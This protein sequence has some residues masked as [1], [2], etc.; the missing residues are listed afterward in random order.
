M[1]R[2]SIF[3]AGRDGLVVMLSLGLTLSMLAPDAAARWAIR[4]TEVPVSRL[5]D[6]T[7]DYIKKNA[8]DPQGYYVLGRL[9]SMAFALGKDQENLQVAQPLGGAPLDEKGLPSFLPWQS[10]RNERRGE[11]PELLTPA[12]LAH[13]EASVRNYRRAVEIGKAA[14]DPKDGAAGENAGQKE[15]RVRQQAKATLGLAWMLEEAANHAAAVTKGIKSP[16][17]AKLPADQQKSL[18]QF[19]AGSGKWR[20]QSLDAYRLVIDQVGEQDR[21]GFGRGPGA[22]SLMS[23]DAAQ[24]IVR[25]LGGK[26]EKTDKDKAEIAK[27]SEL[28]AE[29]RQKPRA[30]TPIIFP[31]ERPQ[32]L[33]ELLAPQTTVTFDLDGDGLASRWPWVRPDTCLLV[34]DPQHNGQVQD[35]RQLF[36]SVTW[37]IF[38]DHGYQPLAS[39]DNDR[40]GW[41]EGKE[42]AGLAAWQDAN[43][44]GVSDPGEVTP[45]SERGIRR[46][47]VRYETSSDGT[48]MNA[49]G[50]ERNDGRMLPTYDWVPRSIAGASRQ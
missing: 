13:L 12:Q 42:L 17:F 43:S 23:M 50:I 33:A 39:L 46:I 40:N 3:L 49:R 32:P 10:V 35:G 11:L 28:L 30:V 2:Q 5:V 44:N 16:E 20:D 8:K 9:H 7:Q 34:W 48:L 1:T 15:Q 18:H 22:D 19:A 27:A 14:K 25:V 26:E 47:A 29:L 41:L 38:W 24:A 21:K 45:L 4:P 31:A 37:W 6:N 36:G